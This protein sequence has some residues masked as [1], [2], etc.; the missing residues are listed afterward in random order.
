MVKKLPYVLICLVVLVL[1]T[2][3]GCNQKDDTASELIDENTFQTQA[4]V[5]DITENGDDLEITVYNDNYQANATFVKQKS[6]LA[7]DSPIQT[8]KTGDIID[9]EITTW[10]YTNV[11]TVVRATMKLIDE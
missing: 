11:G 3:S 5:T 9:V 7:K 8:Y 4:T 2:F 6:K 10:T 1:I